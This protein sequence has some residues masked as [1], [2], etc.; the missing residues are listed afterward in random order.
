MSYMYPFKDYAPE[1][2]K[3]I[4]GKGIWLFDE[5]GKG[6]ID[7]SSGPMTVNLGHCH[8]TIIESIKNQ[9]ERL[10]FAYR[11]HFRSNEPEALAVR[12]VQLSDD[13]KQY[14]FFLNGGSEASEA[15]YRIALDYFRYQGQEGKVY[16]LGREITNHGNTIQSLS[17]GDDRA[18]RNNLLGNPL[19]P[20]TSTVKL[21]P[22]YCFQCPLNK[23]PESCQLECVTESL[24]TIDKFGPERIACVFIEPITAS[25]GGAL[26]PHQKYMQ[27]LKDGLR[28]R[29]IL[30][31]ADEIVTGLGRTGEWFNMKTWDVESDITIIGKGLGAG[32]TPISGLLVSEEIGKVLAP[33]SPPHFI[34]HTYSGNPLSTGIALSVLD[35]LTHEIGLNT[36]KKKGKYFGLLLKEM[37]SDIPCIVDIRGQGLLWAI[38]T[39]LHQSMSTKFIPTG[40]KHGINLYA[41][42]SS[43][44][45]KDSLTLLLTPPLIITQNE[46][47]ELVS[48]IKKVFRDNL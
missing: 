11:F 17:Y 1:L 2:P 13:N 8:P 31:I 16:A 35:V 6:Y 38:E 44:K 3:V 32:F 9:A 10:H 34:G 14:A 45:T 18:R 40:H 46:L 23:S 19:D 43:G 26:V 36:I 33:Q 15:A 48:R 28:E 41:C 21:T 4:S 47:H 25:S 39:T 7:S 12:L 5:N 30:L 29:N 37:L 22:C 27:T 20:A 24:N 42:R